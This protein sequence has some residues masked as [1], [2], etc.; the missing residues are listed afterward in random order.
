MCLV[1]IL[2][3]ISTTDSTIIESGCNYTIAPSSDYGHIVSPGFTTQNYPHDIHCQWIIEGTPNTIIEY[4]VDWLEVQVNDCV[5]VTEFKNVDDSKLLGSYCFIRGGVRTGR[6]GFSLLIEFKTDSSL[7]DRGFKLIYTKRG[8]PQQFPSSP[9][10]DGCHGITRTIN[11]TSKY[12]KCQMAKVVSPGYIHNFNYPDRIICSWHVVGED[13]CN[14]VASFDILRL[15][16]SPYCLADYVELW[17]G[18]SELSEDHLG[19]FCQQADE[20]RSIPVNE[21]EMFV[22]FVSDHTVSGPGFA[23]EIYCL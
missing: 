19:V 3:V 10:V 16:T 2:G 15:Q 17:K 1:L 13:G 20:D 12:Q 18:S 4:I 23:M 21:K 8:E 14:L 6:M 5:N 9:L 11:L 22:R 7:K